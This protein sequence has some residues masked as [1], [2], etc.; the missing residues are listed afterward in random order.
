MANVI[1]YLLYVIGLAHEMI[2]TSTK[3]LNAE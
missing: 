3:Y 2:N 1:G